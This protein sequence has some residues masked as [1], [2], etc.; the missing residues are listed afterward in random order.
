[1]AARSLKVAAS[2]PIRLA[3]IGAG[4]IG[5]RHIELATEHPDCRVCAIVDA[6]PD[7]RSLA[8][9]HNCSFHTDLDEVDWEAID[10]V[11]IATPNAD[12]MRTGMYCL[13]RDLPCLIEKPIADTLDDGIA[14]ATAFDAKGVPLL[15][16]HHRRYHP[17]VE[18]AREIIAEEE[19][20]RPITAS[21]VWAVRKPDEYFEQGAWRK[22][23]DGGPLLINFIHEADLLLHIFGAADEVQAILSSNYRGLAAEDTA[24]VILRMANGMIITVAITDAALSPWSFE[25]ACGENP[26]IAFT[27]QSGWKVCCTQGSFDFPGLKV[28]TDREGR[29]G[30]WSRPLR[31][32]ATQLSNVKP[33]SEQLSHFAA[34][35]R[36]ETKSALVSGDD[37]CAA[38]ALVNAVRQ[39]ARSRAPVSLVRTEPG[40][41]KAIA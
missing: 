39:S 32:D 6:N 19:L 35:V 24:G 29:V 27:G 16:G 34:L 3:V 21:L 7:R 10:A 12:H 8:D 4:L 28:W 15:I 38:L 37:G 33:L 26:N 23:A 13:Q 22:N 36:G 30:N 11:I 25:G 1:M 40:P 41:G 17:F 2:Q 18:R 20:G 14:L 31:D 9:Q 5:E